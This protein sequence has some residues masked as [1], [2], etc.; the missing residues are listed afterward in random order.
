MTL[1]LSCDK[2]DGGFSRFQIYAERK[3]RCC[4][5][6]GG[7]EEE[8]GGGEDY[9]RPELHHEAGVGE[10]AKSDWLV[11]CRLR[12]NLSKPCVHESRARFQP[13]LILVSNVTTYTRKT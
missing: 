6:R 11:G 8:E 12:H 9:R 10:E 4:A 1:V 13:V 2:V 5:R 7:E 3:S